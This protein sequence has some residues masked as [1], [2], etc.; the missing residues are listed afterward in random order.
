MHQDGKIAYNLCKVMPPIKLIG[1][2]DK[3]TSYK[4][5][6]KDTAHRHFQVTA[7]QC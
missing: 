6:G 3:W 1:A 5:N 4:Y 2:G 7:K